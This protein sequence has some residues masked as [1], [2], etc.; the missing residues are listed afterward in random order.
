MIITDS[1]IQ[2][3]TIQLVDRTWQDPIFT[4]KPRD[5]VTTI[6]VWIRPQTVIYTVKSIDEVE[7]GIP[8][9]YQMES[10]RCKD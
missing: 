2:P 5:M 4:N 6:P 3:V 8:V 7:F 10:G 1:D 9:V